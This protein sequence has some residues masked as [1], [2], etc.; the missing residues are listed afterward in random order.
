MLKN[1][2]IWPALLFLA[3]VFL[4]LG[5]SA[6]SNEA[7]MS[8]GHEALQRGNFSQ[9]ITPFR[10]VLTRE[11]RH[12]EAQY[13][14]AI[15]LLGAGRNADAVTEF[16]K[17]INLHPQ[18]SDAWVNLAVALQNLGR[19]A[20]ALEALNSAAKANPTNIT[21]RMNLA[22]R[23]AAAGQNNRAIDEYLSLIND[24]HGQ[25]GVLLNLARCYITAQRSDDAK[26]YLRK[27]IAADPNLVDAHRELAG[28]YWKTDRNR[29]QAAEVY[30]QAIAARPEMIQLREELAT[31]L[32]EDGKNQE[33]A[34][35]LKRA[36]MRIPDMLARQRLQAWIDRLEGRSAGAP[37]ITGSA[38]STPQLGGMQQMQ[39]ETTPPATRTAPTTTPGPTISVDIGDLMPSEDAAAPANPLDNIQPRRR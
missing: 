14:L 5:V 39:R 20:D 10:T 21:V 34:D 18:S 26:S 11:P 37:G 2:K 17:A 4:P 12:F 28:I 13:N 9:A 25:P 27:A 29:T 7:L 16:R 8:Q 24:G 33:A 36:M 31:L 22:S 1:T 19:T 6:Q 15:A 32:E 23:Y 30:R 38:A 3:V 35:Q